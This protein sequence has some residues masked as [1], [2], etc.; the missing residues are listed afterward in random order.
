VKAHAAFFKVGNGQRRLRAPPAAAAAA[1]AAPDGPTSAVRT[2][3]EGPVRRVRPNR[4]C[5]R[6][7]IEPGAAPE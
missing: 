1:A 6:S 7:A 5:R 4:A 2:G 3:A